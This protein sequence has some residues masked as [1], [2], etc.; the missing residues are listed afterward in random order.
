MTA[1]EEETIEGWV[2]RVEVVGQEIAAAAAVN[3]NAAHRMADAANDMRTAASR[4]ES[5]AGTMYQAA[6]RAH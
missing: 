4:N 5:A 1:D 3:E 6:G 2:Q